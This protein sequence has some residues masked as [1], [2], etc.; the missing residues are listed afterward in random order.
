MCTCRNP[1]IKQVEK[2]INT[3]LL[4]G[5]INGYSKYHNET[6]IGNV[7]ALSFEI[8]H[9]REKISYGVCIWPTSPLKNMALMYI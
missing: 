5:E 4:R 1:F 2:S 6:L 3:C 7:H 8:L 9:F